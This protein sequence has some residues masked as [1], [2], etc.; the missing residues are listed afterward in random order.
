[1]AKPRNTVAGHNLERE[2][3][4]LFKRLGFSKAISSRA[5]SKTRDDAKVDLCHTGIFNLQAKCLTVSPNY[6][7]LLKQMPNE[8]D[9]INV[10]SHALTKKSAKGKF[11]RK[12]KYYIV[13]A[14]G[15]E[16][17]LELLA[18]YCPEEIGIE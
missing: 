17:M 1:M 14:K 2:D 11:M 6:P 4:K 15:M 10:V 16:R 13:E 9:Q 7:A 18:K 8:P 5:E 12:G 3:V